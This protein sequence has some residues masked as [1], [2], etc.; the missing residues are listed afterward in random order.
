MKK[1]H[2]SPYRVPQEAPPPS[3]VALPALGCP[4][5]PLRQTSRHPPVGKNISCPKPSSPPVPSV[6]S[7]RTHTCTRTH[8]HIQSLT[9]S[10]LHVTGPSIFFWF[11]VRCHLLE[12]SFAHPS[13][14]RCFFHSFFQPFLSFLIA[15]IS[16]CHFPLY[17]CASL[18]SVSPAMEAGILSISLTAGTPIQ[19]TA[20]RRLSVSQAEQMQE[21]VPAHKAVSPLVF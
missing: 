1:F 10:H 2:G 4:F 17:S 15:F 12:K 14:R 16:R 3:S 8:T 19:T 6:Q 20:H 5:Q 7:A 9:F 13:D 21:G 11:Q 18:S